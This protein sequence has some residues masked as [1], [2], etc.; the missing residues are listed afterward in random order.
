LFQ[1]GRFSKVEANNQTALHRN[2]KDMESVDR[3][4][5]M[6]IMVLLVLGVCISCARQQSTLAPNTG[7]DVITRYH[8]H[9]SLN[10]QNTVDPSRHAFNEPVDSVWSVLQDVYEELG[11][12]TNIV[13]ERGYQVGNSRFVTR[14][15]GGDRL[16]RY[17]SCGSSVGYSNIADSYRVTLSVISRVRLGAD[18]QTMLQT[19]VTGSAMPRQVSGNSVICTTTGR[20]EQRIAEL[21]S[22]L[23]GEERR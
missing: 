17:L 4:M 13:D 10:V 7:R 3:H 2:S 20:L 1:E 18:R 5:K 23:L 8:G 6:A 12:E 11:I 19:E 16:S 9:V 14:R 22:S 15:I 21:T